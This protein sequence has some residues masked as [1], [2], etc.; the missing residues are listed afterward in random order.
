LRFGPLARVRTLGDAFVLVEADRRGPLFDQA[1][2]LLEREIENLYGHVS[3]RPELG[4]TIMLFSSRH[5]YEAFCERQ[6]G[7]PRRECGFFRRGT[8]EITTDGSHAAVALP[9]LSH[10]VVHPILESDFPR[11]PLWFDDGVASL[12]EVPASPDD[13]GMHGET[14]NWRQARLQQALA[15]KVEQ[16]ST[17]LDALFG[18]STQAF[19]ASA[20]E[21]DAAA[22]NEA[23]RMLHHAMARSVCAWMDHQGR[24]WPFFEAW[25]DTF[26]TDPTGEK[27]FEKVMA[28]TPTA[29]NGKWVEWAKSR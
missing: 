27:A 24:L 11:I 9:M 23:L 8:R 25:R 22:T 18:M 21:G 14:R 19:R 3:K 15:S 20:G 2:V 10:E 17:R 16:A 12:L 29:L 5:A 4:V 1:A 13:A 28:S 26:S 6:G 7:D